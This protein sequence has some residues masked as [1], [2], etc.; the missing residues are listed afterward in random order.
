MSSG[1]SIESEKVGYKRPP[2]RTRFQAGVSGNP[3]GRP[4]NCPF[5]RTA[6]MNELA[7]PIRTEGS[8]AAISKLDALVKTLVAAAIA[9]NARAQALLVGAITR[10]GEVDDEIDSSLP[11]EDREFWKRLSAAR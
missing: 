10:M 6:L 4:K 9:G 3:T 11:P 1:M 8:Q 7:A 2:A 5:F